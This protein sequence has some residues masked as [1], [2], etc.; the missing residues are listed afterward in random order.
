MVGAAEAGWVG[1]GLGG[2]GSDLAGLAAFFD[3]DIAARESADGVIAAIA[4]DYPD[5]HEAG[6]RLEDVL[7]ARGPTGSPEG[8]LVGR[9]VLLCRQDRGETEQDGDAT[10]GHLFS[11][12]H[13]RR[14]WSRLSVSAH[15]R[16][17]LFIR[18]G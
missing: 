3:D 13:A 15:Q 6:F 10:D 8:H 9:N 18:T 2:E 5:F 12:A 11:L 17:G 16:R 14:G 7:R 4:D 1:G